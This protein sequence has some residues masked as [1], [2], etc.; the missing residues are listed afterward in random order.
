MANKNDIIAL[1]SWW[2]GQLRDLTEQVTR[3]E[4]KRQAK[5]DRRTDMLLADYRKPDDIREAYGYGSITEKQMDKLLDLWEAR[6]KTRE[7]S[8][9][10]RMK[11]DLLSEL[12]QEAKRILIEEST[13]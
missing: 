1:Q 2:M 10:Y 7:P 12:Y 3:T 4:E 8:T 5:A 6:E 13:K 9:L 11:L